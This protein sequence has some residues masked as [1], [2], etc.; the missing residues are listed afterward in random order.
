M[1][2]QLRERDKRGERDLHMHINSLE[3]GVRITN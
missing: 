2:K 3:Y 1:K